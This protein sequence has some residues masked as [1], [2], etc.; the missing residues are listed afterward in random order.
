V[1]PHY[2]SAKIVHCEGCIL[3]IAG[4]DPSTLRGWG[5]DRPIGHHLGWLGGREDAGSHAEHE[6]PLAWSCRTLVLQGDIYDRARG[7]V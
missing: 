3:D 7:T 4:M 1:K 6:C 5:T 2:C